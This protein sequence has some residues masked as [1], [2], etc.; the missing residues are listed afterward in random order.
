MLEE[1]E[2]LVGRG[3]R[4]KNWDNCNSIVNKIYFKKKRAITCRWQPGFAL[5][6]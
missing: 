1:R 5:K 3:Q 4:R 2:V 6:P